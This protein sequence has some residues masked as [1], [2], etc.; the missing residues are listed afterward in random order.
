MKKIFL[1]LISLF[2]FACVSTQG[3]STHREVYIDPNVNLW[4][5]RQATG[6][7][8]QLSVLIKTAE[9][10]HYPFLR[11]LNGSFYSGRITRRQLRK[12]I[13]DSRILRIRSSK[14][15]LHNIKMKNK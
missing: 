6:Q 9:P 12:L 4:M 3:T 1:F 2:L 14:A 7:D 11:K 5:A 13:K 8:E 15:I 10:V